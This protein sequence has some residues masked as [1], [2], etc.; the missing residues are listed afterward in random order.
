MGG[1][2]DFIADKMIKARPFSHFP[3]LLI[4]IRKSSISLFNGDRRHMILYAGLPA[5]I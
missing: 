1:S 2:R 5:K 4:L 3:Q